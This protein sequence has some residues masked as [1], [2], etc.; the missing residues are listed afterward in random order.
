MSIFEK[1]RAEEEQASAELERKV[2]DDNNMIDIDMAWEKDEKLIELAAK[3][4]E[5]KAR[6]EDKGNQL[7]RKISEMMLDEMNRD[8]NND[9]ASG[10]VD[11]IIM[12]VDSEAESKNSSNSTYKRH[13]LRKAAKADWTKDKEFKKAAIDYLKYITPFMDQLDNEVL[14]T[15][16]ELIR[17]RHMHKVE[18]MKLTSELSRIRTKI[19]SFLRVHGISMSYDAA[20]SFNAEYRN[21]V[22]HSKPGFPKTITM[23]ELFP[24]QGIALPV[25]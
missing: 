13:L 17:L 2:E 1:F 23:E 5:A 3:Y 7:R 21:D 20:S 8:N 14:A 9:M 6:A 18:E 16:K 22:A 10:N 11:E 24:R 12:S 25:F 19:D 15:T 4:S